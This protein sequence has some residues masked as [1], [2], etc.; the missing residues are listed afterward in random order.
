MVEKLSGQDLAFLAWESKGRPMHIA[1]RAVFEPAPG[2]APP[3]LAALRAVLAERIAGEPRLRSRLRRRWL[4]APVWEPADDFA[5]EDHVLEMPLPAPGADP[6]G[7][8]DAIVSAPLDRG[9]PLWQVWLVHEPDGSFALDLKIHHALIDGVAGVALLQRLLG[10]RPRALPKAAARSRTEPRRKAATPGGLVRVARSLIGFAAEHFHSGERT[11]LTGAVETR[12]HFVGRSDAAAL[13]QVARAH[14]GRFND[15]VVAVVAGALRRWLAREALTPSPRG[16]RAYCPVNLR[17]ARSG[18]RYGNQISAWFVPLPL[19]AADAGER[20]RR[21]RDTTRTRKR[22][23]NHQGGDAM[24][25]VVGRLGGWI[26]RTGMAIA[27]WRRAYSVVVTNVPGPTGPVELL[28]ARLA[29]LHAFVPL[30]PGQRLGIAVL[31]CGED[32][33]W[34]VTAGWSARD[35]G[36]RLRDDLEHEASALVAAGRSQEAA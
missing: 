26:A 35:R 30:F 7:E 31:R 29:S 21:V 36:T 17:S 4:R 22:S 9:R 12:R 19:D 34:G 32:L 16:L 2:E 27:A 1:A 28:G 25:R 6:S 10:G 24:A 8:R 13:D 33:F 3:D 14:G 20:L 23:R 5:I 15:A 11:P 18:G